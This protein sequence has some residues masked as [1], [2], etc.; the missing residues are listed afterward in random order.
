MQQLERDVHFLQEASIIDYSL[1][2]GVHEFPEEEVEDFR[3][4]V[5]VLNAEKIH[6][7]FEERSI[8]VFF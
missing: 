1:L 8:F 7:G 6:L 2:L 5:R 4:G 3:V